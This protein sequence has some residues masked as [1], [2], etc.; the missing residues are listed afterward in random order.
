MLI[1]LYAEFSTKILSI[2]GGTPHVSIA[3]VVLNWPK[4]C[5][6]PAPRMATF[7]NT[8]FEYDTYKVFSKLKLLS[9]GALS[10]LK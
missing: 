6:R 2:T 3:D 8:D 9:Y 5:P 4:N 10:Y 1:P 7:L